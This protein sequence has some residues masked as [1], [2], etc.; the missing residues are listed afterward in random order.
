MAQWATEN[1]PQ[2]GPENTANPGVDAPK[3]PRNYSGTGAD[4]Y[5][6]DDVAINHDAEQDP[7]LTFRDSEY[8]LQLNQ[9][10]EV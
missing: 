3:G 2:P 6:T 8:P 4:K 5:S 1:L 9:G 7:T 10:K